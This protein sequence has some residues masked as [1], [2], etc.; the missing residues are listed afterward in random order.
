MSYVFREALR[1]FRRAPMLTGLSAGMIA[2]S[3]FLVGLFG[4]VAYNIRRVLDRV[5]SRV[6]VVAYLRDDAYFESVNQAREQIAAYPEVREVSYISK[7]AALLKAR[8]ELPELQTVFGDLDSNPLPASLEVMLR[9]GQRGAAGVESVAA[10]IRQYEFVEDVRFGSEW[11]EKVFLLRRV[12]AT[13][14]LVLGAAFA[15]VASL[16]IGAAI[17]MAIYARRD[18]INIMR[19]VGATEGFVRQP[20][21]LEGLFTGLIGGALALSVTWLTYAVVSKSVFQLEFMPLEW[22]LFGLAAGGFVGVVSSAIAVRR[23]LKEV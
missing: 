4:L 5:E 14:T 21:V 1:S 18:E 13:A 2:L 11:L 20:F 22:I 17:R 3:L 23:H 9:P 6:E 16:I 19:L 12:A 15:I 8:R 10:R 7:E